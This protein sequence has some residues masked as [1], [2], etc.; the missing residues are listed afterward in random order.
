MADMTLEQIKDFVQA[1]PAQ[2]VL[3][4]GADTDEIKLNSFRFANTVAVDLRAKGVHAGLLKKPTGSNVKGYAVDILALMATDGTVQIHDIVVAS[5]EPGARAGFG[6]AED[7]DPARFADP[8]PGLGYITTGSGPGDPGN[9]GDPGDPPDT[10]LVQLLTDIHARVTRIEDVIAQV[11][12][13]IDSAFG[14]VDDRL[15]AIQTTLDSLPAGGG[16]GAAPVYEGSFRILG[17]TVRFT[18]TPKV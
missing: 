2:R 1:H 15:A 11:M 5:D 3:G 13:Q 6:E 14:N 18:L 10:D 8:D 9:P 12:P 16:A 17:Q 4:T 7:M